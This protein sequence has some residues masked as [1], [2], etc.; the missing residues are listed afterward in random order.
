MNI[1]R[2]IDRQTSWLATL[3]ICLLIVIGT[4]T[5]K[6]WPR[7]VSKDQCGETYL[8]YSDQPGIEA[9]F[10]KDFKVNDTLSV[11]VTLLRAKDSIGWA[12]LQYD[13][14]LPV[15]DSTAMA[16]IEQNKK[17]VFSKIVEK[18]N[19]RQETTPTSTECD[20]LAISIAYHTISV[21]HIIN[22]D[23]RTAIIYHIYDIS[24]GIKR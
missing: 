17:L 13:F 14:N 1:R 2:L 12:I 19:H 23:D 18:T 16:M 22:Y 6:L 20:V 24:T 5:V 15:L 11:D 10:I 7:T 3:A 9:S 21:F 8:R 4:M